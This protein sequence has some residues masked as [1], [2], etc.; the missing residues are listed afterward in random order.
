MVT[1]YDI[2]YTVPFKFIYKKDS[3][4]HQNDWHQH[5]DCSAAMAAITAVHKKSFQGDEKRNWVHM[6]A[7]WSHF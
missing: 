2:P 1:I 3:Q 7:N 5:D 6:K 4:A